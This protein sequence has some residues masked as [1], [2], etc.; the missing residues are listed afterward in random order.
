MAQLRNG[1]IGNEL[2][3]KSEAMKT[4][5]VDDEKVGDESNLQ[6]KFKGSQ[7]NSV[8]GKEELNSSEI[9]VWDEVAG[10]VDEVCIL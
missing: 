2:E 9:I 1:Y 3:D 4:K 10:G 5:N 6:L 8:D 7:N